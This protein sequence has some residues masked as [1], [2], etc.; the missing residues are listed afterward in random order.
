[1]ILGKS[2]FVYRVKDT[3]TFVT[4]EKKK[5]ISNQLECMLILIM[6]TTISLNIEKI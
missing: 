1:M 3:N 6:L 5:R 2:N 4:Y